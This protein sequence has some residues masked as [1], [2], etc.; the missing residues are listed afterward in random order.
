MDNYVITIGR[1]YGSGGRTMGKLLA[2]EL[3]IDCY[4]MELLKLASEESGISESLFGESDE[5]V[6]G[7]SFFRIF[8]G[9]YSGKIAPPSSSDFTS[10]ENL[11]NYQAKVIKQLAETTSCIIIGRCADFILKDYDNVIRLYFYAPMDCCIKRTKEL[12]GMSE[13]EIIKKIQKTDKERAFY[14]EYYTGRKWNDASN[15][16]M[17]LNTE[18]MSYETCIAMVK[19]YLNICRKD[20]K[21]D[22][23]K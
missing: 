3:G 2:Q 9:G 5:K 23:E 6:P 8:K 11:F 20:I 19:A 22:T 7:N 12:Y 10:P 13:E 15:Y 18:S 14:Y 1:S 21:V 16:D 17:C 4:D